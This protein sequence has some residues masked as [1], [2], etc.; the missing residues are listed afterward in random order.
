MLG[1]PKACC[2]AHGSPGAVRWTSQQH[3]KKWQ[4]EVAW[5]NARPAPLLLG[6]QKVKGQ[7][8]T[9]QG[10]PPPCAGRWCAGTQQRQ[11]PWQTAPGCSACGP[12]WTTLGDEV[13]GTAHGLR[14]ISFL[15]R[16]C[17][18]APHGGLALGWGQ[19][20]ARMPGGG[21]G[22]GTTRPLLCY[23]GILLLDTQAIAWSLVARG[24]CTHPYI[25]PHP[26]PHPHPYLHPHPH[27]HPHPYMK[28]RTKKHI[29]T[30]ART[31]THAPPP[32]LLIALRVCLVAT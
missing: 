32:L 24:R 2:C 18:M 20:H 10:R 26:H 22:V 8:G 13:G 19:R 21:R 5:R 1:W 9:H 14:C 30:D 29:Q 27:P 4:T 6:R 11:G 28:T 23:H 7:G 16:P 31:H 17:T 3:P 25:Y 15:G 12:D